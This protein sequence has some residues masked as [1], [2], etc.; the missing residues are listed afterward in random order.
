MSLRKEIGAFSKDV[1]KGPGQAF[2]YHPIFSTLFVISIVLFI[3]LAI[4]RF[5]SG[6]GITGL[7]DMTAWGIWTALKLSLVVFSGCAFT[8]TGMVYIFKMEQFRPF[9]RSAALMGVIGY[10]TFAVTLIFE[11]GWPWRIVHPIFMHNFASIL[12]EVAWCVMIY[13]V[14][15]VLE[16]MPNLFERLKMRRSVKIF[17]TL[18][19]GFVIAGVIISV[20]HQSSLGSLFVVAPYKMNRLWYSPWIGAFFIISAIFCGLA[21]TI[22]AELLMARF[23]R[24]KARLGLLTKLGKYSIPALGLYLGFNVV[25]IIERSDAR[26]AFAAYDGYTLLFVLEIG[27]GIVL[28]IILYSKSSMVKSTK[29]LGFSAALVLLFGGA[30]NRLN[31][32]VM[33]IDHSPLG[34]SPNFVEYLYI[35]VVIIIITGIYIITTRLFPILGPVKPNSEKSNPETR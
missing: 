13:L 34:Y 5:G 27:L 31:V 12:F 11:I 23:D 21:L 3:G 14:I 10:T 22:V 26:K 4:Y 1:I 17:K 19:P 20:L 9:V 7:N 6:L 2:K 32:S 15:L 33:A 35:P 18:T 30:L 25:D 29:G 28:P 24:R 16:F 8:I